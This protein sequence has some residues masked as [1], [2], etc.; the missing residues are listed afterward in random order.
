MWNM[1][2]ESIEI[3]ENQNKCVCVAEI[4]LQMFFE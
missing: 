4:K 3:K 1:L 2:W